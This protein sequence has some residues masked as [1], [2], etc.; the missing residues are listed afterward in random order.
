MK[1]ATS[2]YRRADGQIAPRVERQCQAIRELLWPIV[3]RYALSIYSVQ[4]ARNRNLDHSFCGATVTLPLSLAQPFKVEAR[5]GKCLLSS[6]QTTHCLFR[7]GSV[8]TTFQDNRRDDFSSSVRFVLFRHLPLWFVSCPI[9]R[10]NLVP[11]IAAHQN[12]SLGAAL[13][14]EVRLGIRSMTSSSNFSTWQES[15]SR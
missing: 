4:K 9:Q 15:K 6:N 14:D 11:P 13:Q 2:H 8:K 3:Q 1:G 5:R 12:P 7:G 10:P